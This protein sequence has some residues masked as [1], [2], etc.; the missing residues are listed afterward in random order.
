MEGNPAR[1][2]AIGT[3]LGFRIDHDSQER[4]NLVWRGARFPGYLCLAIALALLSLSVPIVEAIGQRGFAG[5]AGSLW[6][7][8]A[9]N[10]V[11]FGISVY[12]LSLKR[13]I[14]FD[15]ERRQV[16][17]QKRSI[18]RAARLTLRYDEIEALRL[19]IDRLHDSLAIAGSREERHPVPSL[20]VVLKQGETVLLD[21]GGRRRLRDLGQSLSEKLGKPLQVEE[22]LD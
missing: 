20:R 14:Q 5:A 3:R 4:L 10:L 9:M 13:T 2:E 18:F 15:G 12:L 7:F 6:Y 11:L 21:R 16:R 22:G 8:P 1:F 17:L 19:G